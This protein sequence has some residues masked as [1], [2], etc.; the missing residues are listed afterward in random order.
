[1]AALS[2]SFF[3][4]LCVGGSPGLLVYPEPRRVRGSGAGT[5]PD[6]V[7]GPAESGGWRSLYFSCLGR[8]VSLQQLC[9]ARLQLKLQAALEE[10]SAAVEVETLKLPVSVLD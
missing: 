10:L 8:Q 4:E 1:M 7:G 5:C 2:F 3:C 9:Q 6:R